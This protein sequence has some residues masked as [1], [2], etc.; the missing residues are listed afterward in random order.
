MCKPKIFIPRAVVPE[1]LEPLRTRCQVDMG[2]VGGLTDDKLIEAVRGC[3][4][5]LSPVVALRAKVIEAMAPTCK[6]IS[7][8]G[9]GFDHV[10]IAAATR[11]GIWVTHNPG[12]VTDDT[13]DMAFALIL[14]VARRLHECD[15][16]VR[17]GVKPWPMT[18]NIGLRVSGKVLGLVGSGRIAQA[19]AARAAGFGMTLLYTSRHRNDDFETRTGARYASKHELLQRADFVSLHMPLTPE[20]DKYIGKAELELMQPHAILINTARGRVVDEQALADALQRGIIAG[21]GLDVFE[22][23]PQVLPALC[24][25]PN[26]LMTPHKGAATMDG[27]LNMGRSSAEKIF[28]ALDGKLP[29]DCL[30]PEARPA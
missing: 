21:A 19:V 5:I 6:I 14:G 25:L 3:D 29:A 30:N 28:A 27:F 15:G 11:N 17:S 20:T 18:S 4:G 22:N 2:P 10:D 7:C 26:V 13:A 8:F 1:A 9:V 12:F 24:A 23:E 16:Y